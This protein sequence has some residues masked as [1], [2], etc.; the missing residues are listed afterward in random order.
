[1]AKNM[2]SAVDMADAVGVDPKAFRGALRSADL[3]WRRQKAAWTVRRD[4]PQ[5][6]DMKT[7]LANLLKAMREAR[8]S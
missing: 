6:E 8:R 7:V 3:A 5:H 4:S 2:I 1:M